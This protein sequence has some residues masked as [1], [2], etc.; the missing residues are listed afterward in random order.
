MRPVWAD[1]YHDRGSPL[2]VEHLA[3]GLLHEIDYGDEPLH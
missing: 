3:R 1:C 2:N